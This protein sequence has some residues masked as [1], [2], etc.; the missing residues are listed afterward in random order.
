MSGGIA[1]TRDHDKEYQALTNPMTEK[2]LNDWIGKMVR[3][4]TKRDL[5]RELAKKIAGLS[6]KEII[7]KVCGTRIATG[8]YRYVYEI[9]D[10]PDWVIKIERFPNLY[11][12]CNVCEFRNYINHKNWDNFGE[13]LAPCEMIN[14]TGSVM[15]Q[16]KVEFRPMDQY[17]DKI[18]SLFTDTKY[19]NFG[20]IG[21]QFVCCDYPFLLLGEKLRMKRALWWN[22]LEMHKEIAEKSPKK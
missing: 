20:W 17:P 9:K 8:T 18:P 12:F 5:L 13:Y 6:E 21:D 7:K 4:Q 11:M 19:Q 14:I 22:E 2:D 3:K 16:R 1:H 15:V 10:F